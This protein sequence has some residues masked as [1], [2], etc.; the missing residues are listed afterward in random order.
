MGTALLGKPK[1]GDLDVVIVG[2]GR[3]EE[4]LGLRRE[5]GSVLRMG[6]R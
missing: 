4:V 5:E 1:V 6:L 3:E 2:E